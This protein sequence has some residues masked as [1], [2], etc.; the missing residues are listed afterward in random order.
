MARTSILDD[1]DDDA[2]KEKATT[3]KYVY[4]SGFGSILN[5]R[6]HSPWLDSNSNSNNNNNNSSDGDRNR[7]STGAIL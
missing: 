5:S 4:V 7:N 6:T 2:G 3:K 1:S